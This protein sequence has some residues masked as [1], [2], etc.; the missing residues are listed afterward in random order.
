MNW[1]DLFKTGTSI[2]LPWLLAVF[3]LY[4]WYVQPKIDEKKSVKKSLNDFRKSLVYCSSLSAQIQQSKD[5]STDDLKSLRNA[6]DEVEML[7]D[8]V[9]GYLPGE[10]R[11]NALAFFRIMKGNL[12]SFEIKSQN[13]NTRPEYG[14]KQ[15]IDENH[16]LQGAA[17]VM[18]MNPVEMTDLREY[19]ANLISDEEKIKAAIKLNKKRKKRR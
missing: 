15:M 10:M 14:P 2:F 13:D 1:E 11:T 5:I 3:N 4:K 8:L 6:I 17:Y 9:K 16:Y 12:Y 19:L 7:Y 18:Q